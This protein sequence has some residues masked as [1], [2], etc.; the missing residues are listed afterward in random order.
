MLCL[1]WAWRLECDRV[2]HGEG[3]L[4]VATR[5]GGGGPAWRYRRREVEPQQ[6]TTQS[7]SAASYTCA[8]AT[9][10]LSAWTRWADPVDTPARALRPRCCDDVRAGAER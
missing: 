5:R 4:L 10:V 7:T 6:K 9:P 3:A 2:L 8:A 1:E